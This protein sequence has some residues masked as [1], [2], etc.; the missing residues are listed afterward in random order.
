MNLQTGATVAHDP[1]TGVPLSPEG[2][3]TSPDQDTTGWPPGIPYIVGNEVCERFSYYGMRAILFV[4]LVA[5]YT[6]A[7]AVADDANK[8]AR[9]TMPLFMAGVYALPMIGAIIADRFAG[10]F[11][12]ILYLSLFYCLGHAALS[13]W[14]NWLPG[15]YIGLALIAFGSGG[16]K[17]C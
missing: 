3:R 5:L 9:A 6:A 1:K 2:Y 4:H 16:I 14:E 13:G 15:I 7:G 11:R 12:T 10:K 8:Q 17:P